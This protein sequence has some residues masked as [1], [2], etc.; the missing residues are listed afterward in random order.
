VAS[1]LARARQPAAAVAPLQQ[2]G[3]RQLAQR[4]G[5]G[6]DADDHALRQ[7]AV[8]LGLADDV[9]APLLSAPVDG[10]D[11]VALGRAVVAV[12]GAER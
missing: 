11:L 5:L 1:T 4:A 7:A 2:F 10:S 8:G 12:R 6:P 3:R 9:V